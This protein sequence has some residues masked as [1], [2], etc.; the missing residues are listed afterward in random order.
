MLIQT[1]LTHYYAHWNLAHPLL[2]VERQE[3]P[4]R[5]ARR[6]LR[7]FIRKQI[8]KFKFLKIELTQRRLCKYFCKTFPNSSDD[9]LRSSSHGNQYTSCWWFLDDDPLASLLCCDPLPS[10]VPLSLAQEVEA[11]VVL[12][13]VPIYDKRMNIVVVLLLRIYTKMVQ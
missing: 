13:V 6:H 10:H 2:T 9:K 11:F 5:V 1:L 4:R 3:L 8:K 7:N 12:E